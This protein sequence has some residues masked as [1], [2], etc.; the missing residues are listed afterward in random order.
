MA[1]DGIARSTR[2]LDHSAW[3][4][5]KPSEQAPIPVVR[6]PFAGHN[7]FNPANRAAE[8]AAQAVQ[9]A[10]RSRGPTIETVEVRGDDVGVTFHD[11]HPACLPGCRPG[12]VGCVEY[13]SLLEKSSFG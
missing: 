10:A 1:G 8:I 5:Q 12:E 3:R 6:P 4:T 7:L 2:F 13:L 11:C 9:Q